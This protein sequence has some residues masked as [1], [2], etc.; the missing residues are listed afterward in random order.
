MVQP[1]E[2][3]RKQHPLWS[4]EIEAFDLG[5][6]ESITLLVKD[7]PKDWY[8]GS[9]MKGYGRGWGGVSA[10]RMTGPVH[11]EQQGWSD[12]AVPACIPCTQEPEPWCL[13][14]ASTAQSKANHRRLP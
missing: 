4:K 14:P 5:A 13:T 1:A 6:L 2:K 11:L 12:A 8:F 3:S 10:S 7:S 9:T